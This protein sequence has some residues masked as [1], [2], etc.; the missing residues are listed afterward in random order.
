MYEVLSKGMSTLQSVGGGELA[1]M[2]SALQEYE[3]LSAAESEAAKAYGAS[4]SK[5]SIPALDALAE[6]VKKLSGTL[7]KESGTVKIAHIRFIDYFIK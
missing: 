5:V 2:E 3:K 7:K 1:S 6:Q 4:L